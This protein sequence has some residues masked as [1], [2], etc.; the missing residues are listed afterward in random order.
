MRLI[1]IGCIVGIQLNSCDCCNSRLMIL[2]SYLFRL[3]LDILY[4]TFLFTGFITCDLWYLT[5]MQARSNIE[6]IFCRLQY[7]ALQLAYIAYNPSPIHCCWFVS[8]LGNTMNCEV[9]NLNELV[10]FYL[11]DWF[12]CLCTLFKYLITS[13]Y[14]F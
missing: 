8:A 2:V 12:S 5:W 4:C 10:S 9:F 13:D 11:F 7:F 6:E 1:N 14:S 3:H